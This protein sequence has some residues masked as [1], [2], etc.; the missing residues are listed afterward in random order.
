MVNDNQNAETHNDKGSFQ[1]ISNV[2]HS[3]LR[4]LHSFSRITVATLRPYAP[5]IIPVLI[6]VLFIP[7]V[8]L[9]SVSAGF[10]VWRSVAV[11]WETPIYLQFGCVLSLPFNPLDR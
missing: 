6:C 2:V 4:L 11:D 7:L 9:L 8:I 3:P 5:Q 10:V 1:L